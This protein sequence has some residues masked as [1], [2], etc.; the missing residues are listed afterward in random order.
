LNEWTSFAGGGPEATEAVTSAFVAAYPNESPS[1]ASQ[2]DMLLRLPLLKI[3][4]HKADQGGAPVYAYVFTYDDDMGGAYHGA[5]IPFVFAH[6][7]SP[8]PLATQMWQA[9]VSFARDGV[10]S[11]DGLPTWEPYTR[12]GGATMILDTQPELVYGHDVELI[13]TVAPDYAW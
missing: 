13:S 6:A 4:A 11:A 8:Q 7:T 2:V 5:E 1:E 9:W 12:D 3:M 10:P